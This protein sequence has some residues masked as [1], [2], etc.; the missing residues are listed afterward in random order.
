MHFSAYV[1][2]LVHTPLIN[3]KN[4]PHISL[5]RLFYFYA[6]QTYQGSRKHQ[7]PYCLVNISYSVRDVC[8]Q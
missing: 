6:L 4:I 3:R 8:H 1:P 5:F 2:Q 7:L